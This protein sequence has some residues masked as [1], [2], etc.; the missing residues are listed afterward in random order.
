M[1]AAII[2][3]VVLMDAHVSASLVGNLGSWQ[4]A[5]TLFWAQFM[6]LLILPYG[7]AG[8][9]WERVVWGSGD[10]V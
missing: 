6:C 3:F 7:L 9:L 1:V 2:T 5:S 4:S 8:Y 10:L